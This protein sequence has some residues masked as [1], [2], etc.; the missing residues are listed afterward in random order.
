MDKKLESVGV[1]YSNSDHKLKKVVLD[2]IKCAPNVF[3][4]HCA[5]DHWGEVWYEDGMFHERVWTYG[6]IRKVFNNESVEELIEEVNQEFGS[7]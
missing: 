7:G 1:I 2:K 3:A 6:I 5:W 4:E